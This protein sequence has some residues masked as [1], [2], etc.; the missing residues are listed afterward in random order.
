MNFLQ[1][2]ARSITGITA[3]ASAIAAL[4]MPLLSI[5]GIWVA[6]IFASI[7]ALLGGILLPPLVLGISFFNIFLFSPF[8]SMTLSSIVVTLLLTIATIASL[9]F[10]VARKW[11]GQG[12]GV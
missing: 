9:K 1:K 7:H 8:S 6:L 4:F 10:A 3:L 12:G 2:S 11:G 5:Y